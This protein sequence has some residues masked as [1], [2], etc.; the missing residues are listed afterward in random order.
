[1]TSQPGN[2]SAGLITS[3]SLILMAALLGLCLRVWQL[4]GKNFWLDELGVAQAAFQ[5]TLPLAL[6]AAGEHIMAMPLDYVIVWIAARFSQSEGWLRLP[7]AL[8]GFLL[9]PVGYKLSLRLSGSQRVAGFALLLLALS[10]ILISYSQELRFYAPLIFFFT[11][12]AYL[13]L[14]A[15]QEPRFGN[16]VTFTLVTLL[17]IYFHLYTILAV[18]SVLLW[19]IPYFNKE[20]WTLRRNSFAVSALILAV[21]F[22]HGLFTFGGVYADRQLSLFEYESF[23]TFLFTGLGW[24]PAYPAAPIGWFFGI[25][26][27]VLALI[28]IGITLR[29]NAL[30]K[31]ALLFYATVLQIIMIIAFD[32]LKNYPL[33]ARQIVMLVPAVLFF[34]ALGVDWLIE[35][36]SARFEAVLSP[37]TL[38]GAW[39]I[40]FLLAAF[41]A[42]QAYYQSQKGSTQE[43]RAIL[44][45]GWQSGEA[46]HVEAGV[47]DVF[48]F[49]WEQD[50]AS[51]PIADALIPM[52]YASTDG[53]GHPAPAWFVVNYP[54]Q[55]H[56]QTALQNAGFTSVYI[57]TSNT[58]HPQMLWHRP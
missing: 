5:P 41:P 44:S 1:M 23:S 17:G 4:G 30:G 28:G 58:L 43:I 34:S 22:L 33:F 39:T 55:A 24:F 8:W 52:D 16:W 38:I 12:S 54:P 6:K 49:Y 11:A 45:E 3:N 37:E 42:L 40:F 13:G 14:E 46:V 20:H 25:L 31:A 15:V 56:L 19:L 27:L 48:K 35:R 29:K 21:A 7:E 53:W 2:R 9:L 50:P 47:F 36:L 10:P 57:P 32:Y 18:G 51:Q 26:L